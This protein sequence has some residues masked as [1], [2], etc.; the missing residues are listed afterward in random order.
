MSN[1]SL[2]NKVYN[3]IKSDLKASSLRSKVISN[4]IA[5]INTK[6]Y[7]RY[8]VSFEETLN[9]SIHNLELDTTDNRHIK[10][11]EES[12][13]VEVKQDKSSSMRTDGN[14]VDIDNEMANQAA[15]ALMYNAMIS[16]INNRLSNTRFVINGGR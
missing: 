16:Q 3:L 7:K 6:D 10:I 15:N 13:K 2:D 5:N 14:N 8:Y 9:D 11:N 1:I 12:G 4:N